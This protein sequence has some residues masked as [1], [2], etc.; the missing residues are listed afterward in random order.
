[1]LIVT[2]F[3]HVRESEI[4]SFRRAT[5]DNARE[6]VREPGIARFDVLQ[7]ADD[8]SRFVLIEV[9]RDS[10]APALHKATAHYQRWRDVVEPMMAEL[11]SSAKFENVFPDDRGWG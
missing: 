5:V 1:M 6:S 4:E 8:P 2:V 10:Q 11:R 9:Y 7:Q 3:I